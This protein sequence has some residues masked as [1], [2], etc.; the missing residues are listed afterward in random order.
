MKR[1]WFKLDNAAKI[2]PPSSSKKDPKVF[3]FS[4]I[5]KEEIDQ[6]I[7][8][9]A[10]EQ[11]LLSFPNYQVVLK[12]GFFWYYLETTRRKPI[13]KLENKP[14]CM[15]IYS[16]KRKRLLFRVNYYKNRINLEVFHALTDGT[17]ALTFLKVIVTAYCNIKYKKQIPFDYDASISELSSDSFDKYYQPQA[18]Q[19]HQ[20]PKIYHFKKEKLSDYRFRII[21]GTMDCQEILNI[22]R[23]Y[24]TTITVLVTSI[25]IQAILEDM[26]LRDKKKTIII[27]I[28]VNLRKFFQSATARNFFSVIKIS[29]KSEKE[30]LESIIQYV[31]QYLKEQLK[32]ENLIHQ[33]NRFATV[34]HNF[35]VRLIPLFIKNFILKIASFFS[36]RSMTS[37][38]SNVDIIKVHSDL[39]DYI[40]RFDVFV[41]T[42][43]MQICFCSYQNQLTISFTS[44]YVETD[45]I[46]NF[47]RKFSNMGLDITIVSNQMEE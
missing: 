36:E 26:K 24:H 22:A 33:M 5:L 41:S 28:P 12:H 13:V 16:K 34:E 11:A 4:C 7:L 43:K 8:Q 32:K 23:E 6:T 29:Y 10:T 27:D 35:M 18:P 1:K 42:S 47:F 38:V 30:D 37:S 14:L 39:E 31:D 3:R 17:G 20:H 44:V 45:I 9:E 46:K 40:E 21:E 2:F 19:T 25:Y 15:P